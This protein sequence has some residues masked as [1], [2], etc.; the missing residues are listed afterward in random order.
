MT[1]EIEAVGVHRAPKL[2]SEGLSFNSLKNRRK[3]PG[4]EVRIR[5]IEGQEVDGFQLQPSWSR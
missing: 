5:A 2:V 3:A 4:G 1:P